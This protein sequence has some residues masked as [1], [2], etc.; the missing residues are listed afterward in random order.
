[1]LRNTYTAPRDGTVVV[2]HTC[3]YWQQHINFNDGCLDIRQRQAQC[4]VRHRNLPPP[5]VQG[6]WS[7]NWGREVTAKVM[8]YVRQS[9]VHQTQHNRE[10]QMLQYAMRNCLVQ[11]GWSHRI[12]VVAEVTQH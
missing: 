4:W 12:T 8:L 10:S 1:M 3:R 5:P 11:L 9:S 7:P 2:Q 6:R